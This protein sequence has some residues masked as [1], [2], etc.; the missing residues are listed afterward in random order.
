MPLRIMS[1]TPAVLAV[2]DFGATLPCR[3][4]IMSLSKPPS[5]LQVTAACGSSISFAR[6]A[7]IDQHC[8]SSSARC[9]GESSAKPLNAFRVRFTEFFLR[10]SPSKMK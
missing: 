9:Q 2:M 8:K 10:P 7:G 4:S 3:Y 6:S 5:Q 1:A